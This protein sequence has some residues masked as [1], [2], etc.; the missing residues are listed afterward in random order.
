MDEQIRDQ[1]INNCLS[2]KLRRKLLQKGRNLALPQLREIARSMEESEK[3]ANSIEGGS[4]EVRSE[5]NSV[6]GKTN[7]KGDA[8]ARKVK[9]FCCG[10]T[11]HE[12]ND[13][14]CPARGKQ[15]RKCNGSGHLRLCVKLRRSKPVVEELEG[16]VNQ[17][18]ERREMQL[19]M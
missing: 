1:V 4:G 6:S 13:R 18:S 15:C 9:C 2:H 11:G 8:N 17:T 5:V 10:Y 3:Q 12:A 14:R 19:T 16:S 7:Y